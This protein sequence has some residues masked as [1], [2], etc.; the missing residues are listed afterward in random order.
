LQFLPEAQA[1]LEAVLKKQQINNFAQYLEESFRA[2]EVVE[3]FKNHPNQFPQF[4]QFGF[5]KRNLLLFPKEA[6]VVFRQ[7]LDQELPIAKDRHYHAVVE[8]LVLLRELM[9]KQAFVGLVQ[10]IRTYY[11]RRINLLILMNGAGLHF[12]EK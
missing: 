8:V 9:E 2:P 10:S 12:T 7:V 1:E 3:L 11:K 5:F 6:Y 4:I